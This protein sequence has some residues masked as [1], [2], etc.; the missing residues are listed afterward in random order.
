MRGRIRPG[1]RVLEAGCG[2]G[3]NL[4]FFLREGYETYALDPDPTSISAVRRLAATLAPSLSE[5]N[6]RNETAEASSFDDACADVVISSAVL[7]FARDE[8]HFLA[9]LHGSWRLLSPGG[10]FFCRLASTIGMEGR[11]TPL[12]GGRFR[13]LD[14][15]ER[16]LVDEARLVALTASLGGT[17][18][19]PLKTTV[20]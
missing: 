4:V 2:G 9:M 6:F 19:D 14:G 5:S 15:S 8:A 1:L 20:V 7:H 18:A 12:G 13:L 16:F 3:R 17:L 11:F 10:L